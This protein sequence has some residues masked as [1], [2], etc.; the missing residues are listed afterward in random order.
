[1]TVRFG[2]H[3]LDEALTRVRFAVDVLRERV[4][5]ALHHP[6]F[7]HVAPAERTELAGAILVASFGEDGVAR[8][9]GDLE[10]V[11]VPPSPAVPLDELE[12]TVR[13]LAENATGECFAVLQGRDA[14]DRPVLVLVNRALKRVDHLG[15]DLHLS[16]ALSLA[17]PKRDG[18]P[19]HEEGRKLDLLEG[20]LLTVL[21]GHAG[22]L[23]RVTGAG[24]RTW[25]FFADDS[26][27]PILGAWTARHP[28]RSL[29][30]D[31]RHDPTWEAQRALG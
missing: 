23:G 16:V 17:H 19:D 7:D 15:R 8:W 9:I 5:L 31:F 10:V 12:R 2:N 26:A 14:S 28:S 1:V 20:D 27:R 30:I 25:H 11:S 3:F 18:F 6:A 22:Y 4:D 21:R 24:R 13:S 29:R